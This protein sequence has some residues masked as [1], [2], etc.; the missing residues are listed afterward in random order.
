MIEVSL[1]PN[2]TDLLMESI[3]TDMVAA[4]GEDYCATQTIT[5]KNFVQNGLLLAKLDE[6]QLAAGSAVQTRGVPTYLEA[7]LNLHEKY[8]SRIDEVLMECCNSKD[9]SVSE[10]L[11]YDVAA[12][13][14]VMGKS[15]D[16]YDRVVGIDKEKL[17]SAVSV[18]EGH[19][20]RKGVF[21]EKYRAMIEKYRT[22]LNRLE[23]AS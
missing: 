2:E 4:T 22:L 15:L 23:Q 21:P 3:Y 19:M 9:N 14:Y 16:K 1:N 20:E 8:V 17:Q 10:S 7:Q 18:L 13:L 12:A 6:A 5:L 11:L